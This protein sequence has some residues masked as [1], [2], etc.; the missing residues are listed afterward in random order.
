MTGLR[1]LRWCFQWVKCPRENQLTRVMTLKKGLSSGK[2]ICLRCR[3][4]FALENTNGGQS[5]GI[6]HVH[7]TCVERMRI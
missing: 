7:G 5:M 2:K 4:F 6:C 3:T 1:A